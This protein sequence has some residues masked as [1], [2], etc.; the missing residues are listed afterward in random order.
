M[1][2]AAHA[3]AG[4]RA[5]STFWKPGRGGRGFHIAYR[6]DEP[7]NCP[8]CGRSHWHVGRTLAEC[9]FCATA[10]PLEGEAVSGPG[11]FRVKDHRQTKDAR[12]G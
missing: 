3:L 11:T 7:T 4:V 12:Y 6:S 5:L 2:A 1:N 10:I 8:G 9:A